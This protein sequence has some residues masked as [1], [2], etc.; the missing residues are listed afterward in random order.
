M[1]YYTSFPIK[2]R[3]NTFEDIIGQKNIIQSIKNYI[4]NKKLPH[5]ILFY[6]QKGVGKTTL[7]RI[8]SK[9]INYKIHNYEFNILE[10]DAASYNSVE[11]I[12]NIIDQAKYSPPFGYKIYIIDE[13]HMLS[14]SAFNAFLKIL[15]EPPIHVYF[16]LITT[17]KNKIPETILSRCIIYKFKKISIEE[18]QF[19]LKKI[20]IKENIKYDEESLFMIAKNSYGSIRDALY[21]FDKI[22]SLSNG[23]IYKKITMEEIGIIDE[24]YLYKLMNYII[25]KDIFKS[26]ILLDYIL[27]KMYLI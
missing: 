11:N 8:L 21:L 23:K 27:K 13:V 2:Y 4:K 24:Y 12:R 6:G 20:S 15:E 3:P 5:T 26:F 22:S 7:A 16:I 19:F 1:K 14:T 9:K 25:K 17:E 10:L 18:I